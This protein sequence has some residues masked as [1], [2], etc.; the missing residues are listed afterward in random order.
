AGLQVSRQP[1]MIFESGFTGAP[2]PTVTARVL[3]PDDPALAMA[4]AAAH[5]AFNE[6]GTA[7][8]TAGRAELAAKADE[9]RVDGW[10][11]ALAQ[12]MRAGRAVVAAA[13]EAG[14]EPAST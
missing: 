8:G 12:R 7:V 9:L 2:A 4:I 6:P 10:L 11:A 5:L 3:D 1:L 14:A 13:F